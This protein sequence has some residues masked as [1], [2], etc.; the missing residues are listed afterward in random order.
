MTRP[1]A[2]SLAILT[3]AS[4]VPGQIDRA[5]HDWPTQPPFANDQFRRVA[6]G[7]LISSHPGRVAAI[8]RDQRVFFALDPANLAAYEDVTPSNATVYEVATLATGTEGGTDRLAAIT[9]GGLAVLS[10]TGNG[11][12]LAI[13]PP[14]SA[15]ATCRVLKTRI[16][17]NAGTRYHVLA[18]G[19]DTNVA[20]L[21]RIGMVDDAGGA[22]F[23][24][25]AYAGTATVLDIAFVDWLPGGTPELAILTTAGL[26]FVSVNGTV[27]G[28]VSKSVVA[29]KAAAI[30]AS[31]SGENLLLTVKINGQWQLA[32]QSPGGTTVH[33]VLPLPPTTVV[34]GVS[35][36]LISADADL[37][38][39]ISTTD[40]QRWFVMGSD[41]AYQA[42]A[43]VAVDDL[44]PVAGASY[45]NSCPGVL[46]D[47]DLNGEIDALVLSREIVGNI[48]TD[49]VVV[50]LNVSDAI[51]VVLNQP[52]LLTLPLKFRVEGTATAGTYNAVF[53]EGWSTVPEN[54]AGMR[55]VIPSPTTDSLTDRMSIIVWQL[56]P[57]LVEPV[58]M[59][60]VRHFWWHLPT[61]GSVQGVY[62]PI[63]SSHQRY[64]LELRRV[65]FT[66]GGTAIAYSEAATYFTVAVRATTLPNHWEATVTPLM[67]PLPV[68]VPEDW[69]A[70]DGGGAPNTPI[71]ASAYTGFANDDRFVGAILPAPPK[72][73]KKPKKSAPP[74]LQGP[75]APNS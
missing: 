18:A 53:A 74:P 61:T 41:G 34:R 51:R 62:V 70:V 24:T 36:G 71:S 72:P 33:G 13:G 52:K 14:L 64:M 40:G 15:W 45:A 57:N 38:L 27:I 63:P 66:A 12:G 21:V 54:A 28:S 20:G 59:D 7:R 55:L 46:D 30:P 68:P 9:G 44:P 2:F 23:D 56:D 25:G 35:L 19:A 31:T 75:D 26:V 73:P 65:R 22:P 67:G 3:L 10:A 4:S 39:M 1:R 48:A 50:L 17:N 58:A 16:W 47:M 43:A 5:I 37:D 8:V 60:P 11:T 32:R 42:S 49:R 69:L 6:T 29:G